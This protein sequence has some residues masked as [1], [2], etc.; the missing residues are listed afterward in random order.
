MK[1]LIIIVLVFGT[2]ACGTGKEITDSTE[3]DGKI[4][5]IDGIVKDKTN[6]GGCS[7]V[8]E[9]SMDGKTTVL[10]PL[11]LEDKYKVEG[12]AVKIAFSPS[13]RLSK[14]GNSIPITID[15]IAE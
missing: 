6:D 14:C 10:E 1:N 11:A 12:K 9:V 7:F 8:I 4:V 3:V 15:K 13:K 2:F 5:M